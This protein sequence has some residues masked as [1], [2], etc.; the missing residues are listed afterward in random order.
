MQLYLFLGVFPVGM[1]LY[2]IS[3]PGKEGQAPAITRWINSYASYQD[4]WSARNTIHTMAIEAAAF[5]RN[6]FQS[7]PGSAHVDLRF[8]E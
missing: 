7:S 1:G 6:L 2:A 3:R 5:D 8:P 4:K